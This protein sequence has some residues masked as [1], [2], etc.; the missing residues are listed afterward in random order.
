MASSTTPELKINGKPDHTINEGQWESVSPPIVKFPAT[1]VE[2]NL[3]VQALPAIHD[4]K[5]STL[6]LSSPHHEISCHLKGS[7]STSFLAS[8]THIH[9]PH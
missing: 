4:L 7:F 3:R 2:L 6:P 9:D 5:I 1:M 8:S